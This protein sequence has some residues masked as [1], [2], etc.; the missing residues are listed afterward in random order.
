MIPPS[1]EFGTQTSVTISGATKRIYIEDGIT[2]LPITSVTESTTTL[3]YGD[4]F[5]LRLLHATDF[6]IEEEREDHGNRVI[7]KGPSVAKT[8]RSFGT[9]DGFL[10]RKQ[11]WK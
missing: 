8:L 5:G 9:K 2:T 11:F 7:T 4:I 10:A 6:K 3:G 1:D